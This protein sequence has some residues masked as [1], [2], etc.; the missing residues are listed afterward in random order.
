MSDELGFIPVT[1]KYGNT[2]RGVLAEYIVALD[3]GIADG[4]QNSWEAY[5]LTT[6]DG[7]RV[8][9]KS[10]AYIQTWYQKEHS[11]ILFNIRPSLSWNP[12]TDEWGETPMRHSDVYKLG[13]EKVRFGEISSTASDL[14]RD[15]SSK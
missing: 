5:D 8:E 10:S 12:R 15:T 7:I 13:A 6:Q 4:V 9:V 14:F 11:K 1:R 2:E 3:L